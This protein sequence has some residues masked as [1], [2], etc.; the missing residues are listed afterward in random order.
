MLYEVSVSFTSLPQFAAFVQAV[1]VSGWQWLMNSS[2]DNGSIA[3][4]AWLARKSV[5][6]T[7]MVPSSRTLATGLNA[8]WFPRLMS[9]GVWLILIVGDQVSPPSSD[10]VKAMLLRGPNRES[11][12]TT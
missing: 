8:C 7:P 4:V 2:V 10:C 6:L 5:Y 1:G 11:W 9:V 3:G 12:K